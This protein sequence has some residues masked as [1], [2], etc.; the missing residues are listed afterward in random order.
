PPFNLVRFVGQILVGNSWS[1]LITSAVP[2]EEIYG[3]SLVWLT[4]LAPIGTALAVWNIG[5]IGREEGGLKWPMIGAF[6]VFPFSIFHPPLINWSALLS[7]WLFN[8]QEK[9]WRRTPYSKK[10]LW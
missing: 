4:H 5:N 3:F 1:Y 7:A 10:P 8:Q 9:K 2:T 6:A